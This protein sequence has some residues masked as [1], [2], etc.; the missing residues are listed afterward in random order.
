MSTHSY[1]T[2][3]SNQLR[4]LC[5]Y[6]LLLCSYAL[7]QGTVIVNILSTLSGTIPTIFITIQYSA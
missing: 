5:S 6:M 1:R 2:E 3:N 4:I 7:L